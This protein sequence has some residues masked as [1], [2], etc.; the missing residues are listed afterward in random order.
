MEGKKDEKG[1]T[2]NSKKKKI[3]AAFTKLDEQLHYPLDLYTVEVGLI[4]NYAG[5]SKGFSLRAANCSSGVKE[6]TNERGTRVAKQL[7]DQT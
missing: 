2:K 7:F 3:L 1:N 5:W 6:L 4:T